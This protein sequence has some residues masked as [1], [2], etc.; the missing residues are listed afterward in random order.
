[1]SSKEK[2]KRSLDNWQIKL[3]VQQQ[4]IVSVCVTVHFH[5]CS[6][7]HTHRQRETEAAVC[8]RDSLMFI[9]IIKTPSVCLFVAEAQRCVSS[10]SP[11]SP[12]VVLD[13]GC[14]SGILSFFAAQAGARKV[15]AV[16]A[17]TMAQHA[18]VHT[19][20]PLH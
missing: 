3:R 10:S 11:P 2:K 15:Y 16:E 14:G 18:E 12:Q 13:V 19:L 1:M 17:S 4:T 7:A 6:C 9:F 20:N 8:G 5:V